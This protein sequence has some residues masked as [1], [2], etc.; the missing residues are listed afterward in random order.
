MIQMNGRM[1]QLGQGFQLGN[2]GL[3]PTE[4]RRRRGAETLA[5]YPRA[6]PRAKAWGLYGGKVQ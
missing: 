2:Y 6:L 1:S 3:E 4:F 5:V